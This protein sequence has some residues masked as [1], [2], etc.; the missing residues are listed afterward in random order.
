MDRFKRPYFRINK[1]IADVRRIL[2]SR[3]DFLI[4]EARV[5]WHVRRIATTWYALVIFICLAIFSS[6]PLDRTIWILLA[7]SIPIKWAIKSIDPQFH[8]SRLRF[9]LTVAW[10]ASVRVVLS[11]LLALRAITMPS[12]LGVVLIS[13]AA[14][15]VGYYAFWHID[16]FVDSF[17]RGLLS[18]TT[19]HW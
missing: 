19:R 4:L 13:L 15:F 6:L 14:V 1:L 16:W 11:I 12:L 3:A 7:I 10:G 9:T 18:L 5:A 17:R 2:R 8:S